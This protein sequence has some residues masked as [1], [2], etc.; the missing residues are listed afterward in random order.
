MTEPREPASTGIGA[1][2]IDPGA[3]PNAHQPAVV[4]AQ[5]ETEFFRESG[6]QFQLQHNRQNLG[7]LGKFFG[8]SASAPT[9][10]AGIV[11][12]VALLILGASLFVGGDAEITEARKLL[13]GL[14]TSALAFIFGAASKK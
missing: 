5:Q 11:V 2:S 14:I 8:S 7:F 4:S 13:F 3:E 9:N 1:V 6:A 10:I 12:I